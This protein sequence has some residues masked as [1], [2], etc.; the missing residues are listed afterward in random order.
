MRTLM[1]AVI[2]AICFSEAGVAQ[3]Q[4][5]DN[6]DEAVE[7]I[8]EITVMGARSL[9]SLRAAVVQAED[10]VYDL[11]NLLNDDD[12]YDIICK[13]EAPIGSQ[14]PRRICQA[15][16]YRDAVAEVAEEMQTDGVLTR[17]AVN[18]A[19][20]NRLLREKMRTLA[21]ENPDL[22]AALRKRLALKKRFEAER[23]KK[24]D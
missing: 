17:P 5:L 2:A 8:D 14:I 23:A 21:N 13:K 12:A 24:F 10:E 1:T 3:D 22:M 16:L 19:T 20:H 6:D 7:D 18:E 15:R 11:Y 9:G 4:E